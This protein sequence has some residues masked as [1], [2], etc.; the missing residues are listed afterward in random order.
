MYIVSFY[1]MGEILLF[2]QVKT[3][4]SFDGFFHLIPPLILTETPAKELN[5]FK[6]KENYSGSIKRNFSSELI[7]KTQSTLPSYKITTLL[8]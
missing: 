4:H 3:L 7:N 6:E 5:S 2:L 1:C 8:R